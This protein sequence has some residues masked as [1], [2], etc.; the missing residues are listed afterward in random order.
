MAMSHSQLSLD[1]RTL[2]AITFLVALVPSAIGAL[3]WQTKRSYPGRWVLGNVLAA[4]AAG[5]L[6][7]RGTLPDWLSIV[8]ANALIIAA[9][10]AFLQGFRRFRGLPVR[11]WPECVI[12]ALTLAAMIWFRYVNNNIN[13]RILIMG[14]PW[15]P[16]GSP[17]E[18]PSSSK[19]LEVAGW[20]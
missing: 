20:G 7:L 9:G 2:V 13:A 16:L 8:V 15:A 1:A 10:I 14:P 18:S 19:C 11:W 5:L 17:A 6:A 12:A 4:I 3:V